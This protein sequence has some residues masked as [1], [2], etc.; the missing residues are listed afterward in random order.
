MIKK[1]FKSN[2]PNY[3]KY[4]FAI[5]LSFL[6]IV[7]IYVI[8]ILSLSFIAKDSMES[9]SSS[10][11]IYVIFITNAIATFVFFFLFNKL[12][13]KLKFE[14]TLM[15]SSLQILSYFTVLISGKLTDEFKLDLGIS[16]ALLLNII[17]C[18]A[19]CY[20]SYKKSNPYN[21]DEELYDTFPKV[22]PAY[23]NNKKLSHLYL[24]ELNNIIE[25]EKLIG[26][27]NP[28]TNTEIE[29]FDDIKEYYK[30][31]VNDNIDNQ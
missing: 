9:Y 18:I 27:I 22:L 30:Q 13:P 4:I 20:L 2:L 26:K 12:I 10:F 3:L 11:Y 24:E 29:D 1:N 17:A 16:I 21:Y 28:Y 31:Y 6:S 14:T 19:S 7:P 8:V 23:I 15:I 25:N 5:P